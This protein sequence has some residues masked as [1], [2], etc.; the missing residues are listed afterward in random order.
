MQLTGSVPVLACKNIDA[1]LDFYQQALQFVIVNQRKSVNALEWVYLKSGDVLLM[2]ET[3]Y[4]KCTTADSASRTD[5]YT[6]DVQRLHH[7]LK[8]RGYEA[9]ELKLTSYDIQ[10][11]DIS[12]PDGHKLT[13]G[14]R[15]SEK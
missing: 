11:F 9:G 13:I 5:L 10:E 15:N 8:A 3:S 14:Q 6:D 12:D 4:S 2:L 1:T 7:Y